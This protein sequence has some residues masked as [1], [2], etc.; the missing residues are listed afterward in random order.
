M[1]NQIEEGRQQAVQKPMLKMILEHTLDTMVTNTWH[2]K[3][4]RY[5]IGEMSW[6]GL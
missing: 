4:P 6:A 1:R 2:E 5:K 3:Y